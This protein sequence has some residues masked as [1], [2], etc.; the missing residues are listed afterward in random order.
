MP[1]I[2]SDLSELHNLLNGNV[3]PSSIEKARII[4]N[5]LQQMSQKASMPATALKAEIN[6]NDAQYISLLEKLHETQEE[7]LTYT[8]Q[9]ALLLESLNECYEVMEKSASITDRLIQAY[10]S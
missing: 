6:S 4:L 1:A 8:M 9:N 2:T 7:L 3:S 10:K 5:R